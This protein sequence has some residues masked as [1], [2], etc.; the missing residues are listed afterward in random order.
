MN[1]S[2]KGILANGTVYSMSHDLNKF[3]IKEGDRVI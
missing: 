3:Y 1:I 2:L